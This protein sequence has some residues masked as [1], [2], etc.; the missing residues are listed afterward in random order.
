MKSVVKKMISDNLINLVVVVIIILIITNV[1][2]T[3]HNNKIIEENR[4][5]QKEAENIKVTFSQFAIVIIHNLDLSV[6]GYA[7]FREDKYLYPMRFAIRDKDSILNVVEKALLRQNYPLNS[8]Y[9]LRDSINAYVTFSLQMKQLIDNNQE[10]TFKQAANLDKGYHLW[11]QYEKVA[12]EVYLFEDN[13]MEKAKSR[14]NM[15]SRNN[16][17][18][19]L[20]LFLIGVPTLIF[21]AYHSN[22][23]FFTMERLKESEAEKAD[24]LTRQNEILE[25]VVFERTQEI[26]TQ[27][28]ELQ[29]QQEEIIS[30]IEQLETQNQQLEHAKRWMAEQN[31]SLEQEI[32]LRTKE[33]LTFNEQIEQFAFI[34]AHSLRAP[35]ARILG[36]G[37]LLE[38][39]QPDKEDKEH[40]TNRLVNTTKELDQV[41]KDLNYILEIK[42]NYTHILSQVS[43]Q[44]EL[45]KILFTLEKEITDTKTQIR[46]DFSVVA[47]INTFYPYIDSIFLNLI[48]NAIKYRHPER[49]PVIDIKTYHTQDNL[50]CLEITDNGLG[51]NLKAYGNQLFQLYKRFHL[52]VEGKGIGL[53]LVKTQV[54]ALGG[55][56]E[57]KSEPNRGTTF[58][59]YL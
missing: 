1:V 14:Y 47:T 9:Q 37:H 22:Q 52:N 13:I 20:L 27:N 15:A 56:I 23:R 39:H 42:K 43:F 11:L 36:L 12:D 31:E 55:S 4:L 33:I 6:R 48:S 51:I 41:I 44:A 5:M 30:H 38:I 40:I 35:V 53:Y 10:T 26:H 17:I 49:N 58:L 59:I 16:Y 18:L 21:T 24:I 29:A 34:A 19:Q 32:E 25:R 45:D 54:T 2:F 46:A 3:Y 28:E 57:V 50:I 8:F 7:I